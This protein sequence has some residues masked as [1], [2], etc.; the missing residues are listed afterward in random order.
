MADRLKP[1]LLE[2]S[3]EAV[4]E[5]GIKPE[6]EDLGAGASEGRTFERRKHGRVSFEL[7]VLYEIGKVDLTGTTANVCNEG[8]LVETHLPSRRALEVF[9]TLF[10]NEKHRLG[11]RYIH[12][13]KTY[14]RDAEIKH[15]HLSSSGGGRC[16]LLAG[17]WVPRIRK[18]IQ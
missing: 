15:F 13:G 10:R 6:Q 12:K 5:A 14:V 7:P 1:Y 4:R 8:M 2:K 17:F 16:R 11:I 3:L 9:E 18:P